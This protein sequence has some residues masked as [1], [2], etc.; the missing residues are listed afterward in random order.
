MEKGHLKDNFKQGM[1]ALG[2]L[3]G[4]GDSSIYP[5][6]DR[7]HF[8]FN[9]LRQSKKD[10]P[11]EHEFG[12]LRR[13][14]NQEINHLV[15]EFFRDQ[16]SGTKVDILDQL[17]RPDLKT[18]DNLITSFP[19]A[20]DVC[21]LFNFQKNIQVTI[22]NNKFSFCGE[23]PLNLDLEKLRL[24]SYRLTRLFLS[25]NI[26]FTF[27]VFE[28]NRSD[29]FKIQFDFH[30]DGDEEPLLIQVEKETVLSLSPVMKAF[31]H[32]LEDI[33]KLGEHNIFLIDENY[34]AKP[35]DRSEYKK[36]IQDQSCHLFHFPFLFR[37]ISLII[38]TRIYGDVKAVDLD[39]L[40]SLS[41]G[42]SLKVLPI[43]LFKIFQK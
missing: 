34:E 19:L 32:P 25:K 7:L 11:R 6:I 3:Y 10:T 26:L 14:F 23:V 28:T 37:P 41:E 27:K 1:D 13:L 22:E 31:T 43:N 5:V 9:E 21:G 12:A 30:M 15:V 38:K 20:S 2:D 4:L 17:K 8:H 40:G 42:S 24:E 29:N 16:P 36:S 33:E 35:L 39:G 18:L